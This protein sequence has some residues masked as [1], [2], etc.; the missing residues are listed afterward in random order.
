ME[1]G[2]IVEVRI[3]DMSHEGQGI[4]RADG[5]VVFVPKTVVG[6]VA[7]AEL[8]KVKKNYAFSRLVE[9]VEYSDARNE[10]FDCEYFSK[11]CGGCPLGGITY[12]AQ[13]ELKERQV[14]EKIQRLA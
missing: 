4:G 8:T 13:L 3:E 6:D 10:E 1:K 7:K 14:R 5:L 2:Q 11:G 9:I 12:D